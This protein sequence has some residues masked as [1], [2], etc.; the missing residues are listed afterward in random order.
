[1]LIATIRRA[2]L[3]AQRSPGQAVMAV[4]TGVGVGVGIGLPISHGDLSPVLLVILGGACVAGLARLVTPRE[5]RV[6]LGRVLLVA[7][8]IRWAA[9]SVLY[10]GSVATGRG[11]VVGD[12]SG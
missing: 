3:L 1:M 11:Y 6:V 10:Y 2:R 4:L 7:L 8:S 5:D 12:D 9:A